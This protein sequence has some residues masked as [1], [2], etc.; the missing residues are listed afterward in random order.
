ML[1]VL[2]FV[3]AERKEASFQAKEVCKQVGVPE[4]FTRK[5]LQSLVKRGL[6]ETRRGP[7]GGYTFIG[8]SD[9]LSFLDVI[10][11]VDGEDTFA[12]CILGARTH[13]DENPCPFHD[14][15][16]KVRLALLEYLS[17]TRLIR[18]ERETP[19]RQD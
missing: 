6:L 16:V 12:Q 2:V 11:S 18:R 3:F 13:N 19:N 7:K 5:I 9:D 8:S 10:K 14:S 1:R 15:W 4:P 17:E